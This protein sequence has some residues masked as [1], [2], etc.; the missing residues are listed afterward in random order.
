M[1]QLTKSRLLELEED[2]KEYQQV[3]YNIA[4]RVVSLEH[5]WTESDSNIGGGSSGIIIKP[6]EILVIKKDEDKELQRLFKL[7][8][9]C[10]RAINKM[11]DEQLLMYN[12]RFANSDYLG[13][14]EVA[15][16]LNYSIAGIY[17][18]RYRLLELLAIEKGL[19][20][21]EKNV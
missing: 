13:W 1:Q 16:R 10:E 7:K 19:I 14:Q 11:S 18:K 12:M 6:Q 3:N 20:S 8:S 17:K 15:D 9:D 2:F 21:V 5:P 4:V